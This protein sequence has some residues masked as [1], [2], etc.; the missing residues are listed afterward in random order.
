MRQAFRILASLLA[1]TAIAL[2]G[3]SSAL[4]AAEPTSVSLDANW[5]YTTGSTEYCYDIDGTIRYLDTAVGSMVT[6]NR[7]T[8]TTVY[9]AGEYAGETFAVTMSRSAVQP[10][11]TVVIET[12]TNTRST[13]GEEP[14]EY[15]LV[16][17]LVDYEAVVYRVEQTCT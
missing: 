6:V 7:T 11:G 8:R 9:E 16:M 12:I 10:D 3:A 2:A 14:C 4:A 15:R 13:A 17:R 5:C 1:V